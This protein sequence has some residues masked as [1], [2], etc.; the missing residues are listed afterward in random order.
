MTK[1]LRRLMAVYLIAVMM[2]CLFPPWTVEMN[3]ATVRYSSPAEY[4]FIADPPYV[5]RR[6]QSASI[7]V[8][9][10]FLMLA[11]ISSAAG[12]V[13]LWL[14][15]SPGTPQE[16]ITRTSSRER[17]PEPSLKAVCRGGQGY[18]NHAVQVAAIG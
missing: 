10:F 9:R 3:T 12:I 8:V 16:G 4:R 6:Y 2:S 11:A 18:F 13:A 15:K 5:M 1:G 17:L 7:D 14:V